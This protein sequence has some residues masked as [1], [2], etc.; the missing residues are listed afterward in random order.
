MNKNPEEKAL[1]TGI[2]QMHSVEC[3]NLDCLTKNK[4]KIYLPISNEWS[5]RSKQAINDNVF[6]LHFVIV[7]MNFFLKQNYYSPELL[8]NESLYYLEIL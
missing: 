8:I 1:L 4:K 2:L 3:P 6:L 7:I 5:D